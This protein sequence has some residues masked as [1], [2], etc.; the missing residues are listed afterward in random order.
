MAIRSFQRRMMASAA[1]ALAVT[2]TVLA[3]PALAVHVYEP[4]LRPVTTISD[5]RL[6]IDTPQGKAEFPLY[7][8][9]D[10]NVPQPQLTRAVIVIHGKLRNADVYFHTAEK[11]Q[12]AAGANPDDTLLIAPQFLAELD[13]QIHS[14]PADLLRWNDNAWMGGEPAQAPLP[15]SS[16][17]VLDAIVEHL[18]DRK[19]FPHLQHVV[20]AGHSGGAQVVQRYAVAARDL[21]VLSTEGIDVRYVV[22]SPSSYAYFD[23]QRPNAQGVAAPFNASQCADFNQWKYGMDN[24]PAYL[25]DRTPQELEAAYAARRVDYLVGG[26]D[27][28]P[29]QAALDRSCAAQAQG[30]ERVA[31]A[32]GYFH[33]MQARHPEGLKQTFHVVP[34]VGH[35]GARMLTSEC[36]LS[37]MFGAPG[38]DK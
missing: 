20:F 7:L 26:N 12:R 34:G 1:S 35:N 38:C 23:A 31:R 16:Y 15:I 36:A 3:Q 28:D 14:E 5:T 30:E 37:A 8:S 6:T 29:Q 21:G 2:L 33:Y 17:G 22:S 10:W 24:R 13:T 11:A 32:E 27:D 25:N 4:H 9:K 18:A 19:L